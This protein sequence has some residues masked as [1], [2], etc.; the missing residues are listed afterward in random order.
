MS[1]I[2]EEVEKYLRE[3]KGPHP[4]NYS[5]VSYQLGI[6]RGLEMAREEVQRKQDRYASCDTSG[7]IEAERIISKLLEEE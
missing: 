6:R 4:F 5:E 1:R 2:K 3:M 7:L